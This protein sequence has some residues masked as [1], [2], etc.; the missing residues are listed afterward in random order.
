MSTEH[1]QYSTNNQSDKIREYAEKRGIE[2]VKTYADDGKSGLS[3]GGRAAL[4]KLL[5]DVESGQAEFNLNH[6]VFLRTFDE[7]GLRAQVTD[8]RRKRL[9]PVGKIRL[10][11][12]VMPVAEDPFHLGNDPD[13][14][15][16]HRAFRPCLR[17]G[18]RKGFAHNV[19]GYF[20]GIV[21]KLGGHL[22]DA[23]GKGC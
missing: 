3:I 10:G 15:H 11:Q 17:T 6:Y 13:A 8:E 14:Q 9:A 16:A 20:R 18:Q 7:V 12:C 23:F 2:I 19:I 21:A 22:P 1:Q 4:Q 5:S